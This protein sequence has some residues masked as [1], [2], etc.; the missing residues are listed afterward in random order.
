MSIPIFNLFI[1]SPIGFLQAL[2]SGAFLSCS[3]K[4]GS[5][6]AGLR[7]EQLAPARIVPPLRIPRVE[8]TGIDPSLWL[9]WYVLAAAPVLDLRNFGALRSHAVD[10]KMEKA[11]YRTIE[12]YRAQ[13]GSLVKGSW[14]RRRLRDSQWGLSQKNKP[15]WKSASLLSPRFGFAKPPP[16]DKGGFGLRLGFHPVTLPGKFQGIGKRE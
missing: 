13:K 15:M 1:C 4:K 14:R 8:P 3:G 6:E 16:F 5:K 10:W 12:R 9:G 7:G 11:Q 2:A